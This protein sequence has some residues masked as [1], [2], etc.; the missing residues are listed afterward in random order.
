VKWNLRPCYFSQKVNF[1]FRLINN[2][3]VLRAYSSISFNRDQYRISTYNNKVIV[4]KGERLLIY[5]SDFVFE[6]AI[7]HLQCN[8]DLISQ[9][10]LL[11]GLEFKK[12]TCSIT[13][14][15]ILKPDKFILKQKARNRIKNI[16]FIHISS[17]NS[18]SGKWKE[19][20]KIL[21]MVYQ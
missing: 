14:G 3:L 16:P 19:K 7:F 17:N 4:N 10:D 21:G 6:E 9:Y 11:L 13:G 1:N 15:K 18:R 12:A 8:L 20:F 5:E 2:E